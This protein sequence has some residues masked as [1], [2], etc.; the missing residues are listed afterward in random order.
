MQHVSAQKN[1]NMKNLKK[2]RGRGVVVFA[3]GREMRIFSTVFGDFG[4]KY[5]REAV[6]SALDGA[7]NYWKK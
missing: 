7:G 5:G 6:F 4:E 2:E 3:G 1:K